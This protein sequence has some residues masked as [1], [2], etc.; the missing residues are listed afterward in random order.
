MRCGLSVTNNSDVPR[1]LLV[2]KTNGYSDCALADSE[3][4]PD[5]ANIERKSGAVILPYEV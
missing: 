1:N 5:L 3:C 2:M 4:L